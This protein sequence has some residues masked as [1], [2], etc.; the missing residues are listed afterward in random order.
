MVNITNEYAK[1]YLE[2]LPK[3]DQLN[4]HELIPYSNPQAIDLLQKM[5]IFNPTKRIQIEEAL[6]HP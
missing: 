2:S 5:L 4:L 1:K 6:A 3:K